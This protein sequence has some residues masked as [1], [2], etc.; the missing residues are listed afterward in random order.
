MAHRRLPLL[1]T[2]ALVGLPGTGL[3]QRVGLEVTL[4]ADTSVGGR[5]M[6]LP[7]VRTQNLLA[8]RWGQAVRNALPLRLR[9][10]LEVWRSRDSW[11][12]QFER[13]VSWEIVIRHEVLFDHYTVTQR[14]AGGTQEITLASWEALEGYL[15]TANL[16]LARPAGRGTYYYAVTLVVTTLSEEDLAELERFVQGEAVGSDRE[17]RRGTSGQAGI[18]FLLRMTGGLPS[19]T[20]EQRTERFVV[21]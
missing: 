6:R 14:V 12:D 20:I 9:F 4:T 5:Q 1:L 17:R 8:G 18:R 3:A 2:L 16:I 19:E 13:T 21:R 11:I 10:E 15:N 7:K